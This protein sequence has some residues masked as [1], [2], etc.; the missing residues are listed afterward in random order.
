MSQFKN[1]LRYNSISQKV[2][3]AMDKLPTGEYGVW[4]VSEGALIAFQCLAEFQS[5]LVPFVQHEPN[6]YGNIWATRVILSSDI[7]SPL[8]V[9]KAKEFE[10]TIDTSNET[11]D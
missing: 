6:W 2:S 3:D 4:L 10:Y 5:I 8:A 1:K 7:A 9:L 11:L